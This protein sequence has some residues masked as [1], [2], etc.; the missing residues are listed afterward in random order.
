[1]NMIP[2]PKPADSTFALIRK[3]I[4]SAASRNIG[5]TCE[6][7]NIRNGQ[8]AEDCGIFS[9]FAVLI[10]SPPTVELRPISFQCHHSGPLAQNQISGVGLGLGPAALWAVGPER[11]RVLGRSN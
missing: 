10:E 6:S 1:M 4:Q 5:P 2:L 3:I 11:G 8:I 9:D 7:F